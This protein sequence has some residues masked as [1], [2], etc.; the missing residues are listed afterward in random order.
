MQT[1]GLRGI[2]VLLTLAAVKTCRRQ[3]SCQVLLPL[4]RIAVQ[5]YCSTLLLRAAAWLHQPTPRAGRTTALTD[6]AR[7][8]LGAEG[9]QDSARGGGVS[10]TQAQEREGKT[11]VLPRWCYHA[12]AAARRLHELCCD[13][14]LSSP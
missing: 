5:D 3:R 7:T 2:L 1:H 6:K 12:A 8:T 10:A 14:V 9:P 13:A 4:T 11:K